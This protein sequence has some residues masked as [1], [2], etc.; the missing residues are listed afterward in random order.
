M[1]LSL[2]TLARTGGINYFGSLHKICKKY[3]YPV[4]V[5]FGFRSIA[6][7]R[8]RR[9]AL[10]M[11]LKYGDSKISRMYVKQP[12]TSTVPVRYPV[13]GDLHAGVKF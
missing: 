13:P 4:P 2:I 6:P 10:D 9:F 8:R 1:W 3:P 11:L 5:L 7:N 12:R